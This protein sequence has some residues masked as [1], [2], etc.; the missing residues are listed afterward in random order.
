[1]DWKLGEGPGRV[2]FGGRNEM[3]DGGSKTVKASRSVLPIRDAVGGENALW[4][5]HVVVTVSR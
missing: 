1:M 2:H 3:V 4:R 5:D